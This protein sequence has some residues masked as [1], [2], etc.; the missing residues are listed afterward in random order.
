MTNEV[1]ESLRR[2]IE[3]LKAKYKMTWY[4]MNK[5]EDFKKLGC[6]V[7]SRTLFKIMQ[8]DDYNTMLPY[9]QSE[10]LTFFL[11]PHKRTFGI[12]ELTKTEKDEIQ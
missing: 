11:T 8:E 10:L 4:A 12:I 2:S 6:P 1:R 3:Q 5:K 9:K 7:S